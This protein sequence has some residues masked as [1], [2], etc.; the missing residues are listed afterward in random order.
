MLGSERV[1]TGWI[2]LLALPVPLE[3]K[4]VEEPVQ[5]RRDHNSGDNHEDKAAE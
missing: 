4:P 5:D 3:M 1:G 2:C